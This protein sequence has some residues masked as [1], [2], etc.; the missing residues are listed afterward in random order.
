MQKKLLAIQIYVV[1]VSLT[2]KLF[3][4][5]RLQN[6]FD[7]YIEQSWFSDF[8]YHNISCSKFWKLI[9]C[10]VPNTCYY[11]FYFA[12]VE[13]FLVRKPCESPGWGELTHPEVCS[14]GPHIYTYRAI[15]VL[16]YTIFILIWSWRSGVAPP[17]LFCPIRT[18][19]KT[20]CLCGG[21]GGILGRFRVGYHRKI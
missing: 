5:W 2:W 15:Y 1:S 21:G 14:L 9:I 20:W 8:D 17:V 18:I 16:S 10:L 13:Y 4:Y 19:L 12:P 7:T 6:T 11:S 3:T